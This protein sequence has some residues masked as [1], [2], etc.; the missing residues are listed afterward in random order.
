V[1]QV[2][3]A[4]KFGSGAG[5]RASFLYLVAAVLATSVY[6]LL[7]EISQD[8]LY[9]F[10]AASAM[11]VTLVGARRQPAGRRLPLYLLAGGLL[12]AVV[13]EVIY[14]IYE[15]VLL[16]EDPFPSLADVFFVANYPFFAAALVLLIRRRTP[17]RDWGGSRTRRS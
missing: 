12:M 14:M 9:I 2:R 17:G 16:V 13:G 6:F 3:Q 7:P 11:G 10:V 5:L 4:R 1:S 15:D 8:V